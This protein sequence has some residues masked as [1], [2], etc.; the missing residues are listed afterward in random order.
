LSYRAD[1]TAPDG[2]PY[3]D[4]RRPSFEH[5]VRAMFTHIAEGYEGFDHLAS[6][7]QDYLWRPRA[8]WQVDRFR[9][10][11]TAPRRILDV[12]CGTGEL[13]RLSAHHYPGALV[14]GIDFTAAMVRHAFSA[15]S[16]RRGGAR[17]RYARATV[18]RL[19]FRD[20]SFDLVVSAFVARNLPSL[21][22]AF[23]ELARVLAPGGTLAVLDIT[24]PSDPRIRALFLAYFD[25]IVPWLGAAV[26]SAGPYRY[27]PESLR[28][29]PPSE[30]IVE[31]LTDA[32]FLRAAALPQSMGIVTTFLGELPERAQ[33]R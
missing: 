32:G 33:S 8:L 5:D 27:L 31:L 26:H 15:T 30:R 14:V 17:T 10:G 4:R 3:P 22:T 9:H 23:R 1:S 21:S 18:N 20:G 6:L 11:R 19:P 24:G 13:T 7:G 29:L 25:R 16:P 12:G 2:S 28:H